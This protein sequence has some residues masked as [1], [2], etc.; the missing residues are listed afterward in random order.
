[1]RSRPA[2]RDLGA[3]SALRPDFET[4]CGAWVTFNGTGVVAITK[5][6]N[7]SSIT[8]NAVGDWTVNLAVPMKDANYSIS[9]WAQDGTAVAGWMWGQ[10]ATTPTS[11]VF[12]FYLG[13]SGAADYSRVSVALFGRQL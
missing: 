11:S 6:Y 9:S 12:R 13:P 8:D 2:L 1:M 5:Q 7:V 10:P 3:V 4:I